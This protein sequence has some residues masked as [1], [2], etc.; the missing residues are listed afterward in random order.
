M[1]ARPVPSDRNYWSRARRRRISR[2]AMLGASAKAG[3]GAAAL[4]LAGCGD[5][6]DTLVLLLPEEEE[7]ADE[8]AAEDGDQG[9]EAIEKY[10][11]DRFGPGS[12][13][14]ADAGTW[15]YARRWI[16][17]SMIWTLVTKLLNKSY[18]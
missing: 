14:E 18:S 2:R 5:D 15:I 13:S 12:L 8:A 7:E 17:P 11:R 1:G 4:A 10:C 9:E 3:I 6:D 16:G